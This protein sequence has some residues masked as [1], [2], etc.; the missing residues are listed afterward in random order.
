MLDNATPSTNPAIPRT[1]TS[2]F[3]I[4]AQNGFNECVSG[5]GVGMTRQHL[6]RSLYAARVEGSHRNH[7]EVITIEAHGVTV[8]ATGRLTEGIISSRGLMQTEMHDLRTLHIPVCR[9]VDRKL[10]ISDIPLIHSGNG[11]SD[12]GGWHWDFSR[13]P[14]AKYRKQNRRFPVFE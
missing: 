7:A 13:P 8:D 9:V 10:F 14:T 5:G 12:F 6:G 1:K 2:M 4:L 11:S 3:A